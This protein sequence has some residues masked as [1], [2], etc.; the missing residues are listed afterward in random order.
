MKDLLKVVTVEDAERMYQEKGICCTMDNG[1]IKC[2]FEF[3]DYCD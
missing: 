1:D 2:E 3:E